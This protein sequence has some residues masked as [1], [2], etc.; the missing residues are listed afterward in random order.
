MANNNNFFKNIAKALKKGIISIGV[1]L[2]LIVSLP[3]T[4]LSVFFF[5]SRTARF[6]YWKKKAG[7]MQELLDLEILLLEYVLPRRWSYK[8][9]DEVGVRRLCTKRELDYYFYHRRT[10]PTLKEMSSYTLERVS[11][12]KRL[13]QLDIQNLLDIEEFPEIFHELAAERQL[14]IFQMA[15]TECRRKL[16]GC[17]PEKLQHEAL[18]MTNDYEAFVD[19]GFTLSDEELHRLMALGNQANAKKVIQDYVARQTP[20]DSFIKTLLE[21]REMWSEELN[22]CIKKY[23]L[24]PK[25]IQS[26]DEDTLTAFDDQL[27]EYAERTFI[28]K[29]TDEPTL[30]RFFQGK[31]MEFSSAAQ[32][33]MKSWQYQIYADC[34]HKLSDEALEYFL[35]KGDVEIFKIFLQAKQEKGREFTQKATALIATNTVLMDLFIRM[36]SKG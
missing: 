20:P 21:N 16:I 34:G 24:S 23:G 28:Q 36:C 9:A 10:V 1:V 22:F 31:D 14:E 32:M 8:I 33:V 35:A 4:M 18:L 6:V 2:F 12:D 5:P 26:L 29:A 25:L 7:D 15:S 17:L 13:S 30:R 11:S 19:W 3:F 27:S